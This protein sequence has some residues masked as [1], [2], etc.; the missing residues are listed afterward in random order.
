MSNPIK[1][2][3]KI[4]NGNEIVLLEKNQVE[5]VLPSSLL[6]DKLES[7]LKTYFDSKYTHQTTQTITTEIR[8]EVQSIIKAEPFFVTTALTVGN[9]LDVVGNKPEDG[10]I[11]T[12]DA[13]GDRLLW[14]Q[15]PSVKFDIIENTINS[16]PIKFESDHTVTNKIHLPFAISWGSNTWGGPGKAGIFWGDP[17]SPTVDNFSIKMGRDDASIGETGYTYGE[18]GGAGNPVIMKFS[19]GAERNRG[20]VWTSVGSDGTIPIMS[21]S[22]QNSAGVGDSAGYLT[23]RKTI[24]TEEIL[25]AN[26]SAATFATGSLYLKNFDPTIP[27]IGL[28]TIYNAAYEGYVLTYTQATAGIPP[29]PPVLKLMPSAGGPSSPSYSTSGGVIDCG[30]FLSTDGMIDC[31]SF[32]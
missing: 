26:S 20:F 3:R 21:L 23:V 10:S 32:I 8:N 18:V 12:Y 30:S 29:Q 2:Y 28:G 25:V 17:W 14:G 22:T 11:I 15:S 24:E 27:V 19:N 9:I 4:V 7:N 16:Y 31:G 13:Q 6:Y 5:P 1:R